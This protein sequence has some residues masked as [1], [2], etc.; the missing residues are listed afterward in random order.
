MHL[1]KGRGRYSKETLRKNLEK[2]LT[3]LEF[4]QDLFQELLCSMP[5]RLK[6][7]RDANGGETDY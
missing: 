5:K 3:D 6:Q 2:V 7:V 1:E 4:D